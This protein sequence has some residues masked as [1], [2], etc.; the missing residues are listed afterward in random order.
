MTTGIQPY[1]GSYLTP[2][3]DTATVADAMAPAC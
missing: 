2:S 3:F 1:Q